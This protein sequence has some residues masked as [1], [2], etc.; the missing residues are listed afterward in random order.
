MYL[1]LCRRGKRAIVP[2]CLARGRSWAR[3]G[4]TRVLSVPDRVMPCLA[5][6]T[7]AG[8]VH[9]ARFAHT[10]AHSH[11][12]CIMLWPTMRTPLNSGGHQANAS[13]SA[14]SHL[15]PV[16]FFRV[17][18]LGDCFFTETSVTIQSKLYRSIER[19]SSYSQELFYQKNQIYYK[20]SPEVQSISNII[21]ITSRF[22]DHQ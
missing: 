3:E 22:R 15:F 2:A 17:Y 10:E 21:K 11:P 18:I 14:P 12:T 1:L 6:L 20:G 7:K 19:G 9:L 4:A 5:L 13:K 8:P 16:S